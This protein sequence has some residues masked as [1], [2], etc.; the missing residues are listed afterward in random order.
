MCAQQAETLELT[1]RTLKLI[2]GELWKLRIMFSTQA[3]LWSPAV[4][5][6]GDALM[7]KGR[8]RWCTMKE[9]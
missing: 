4:K 2:D 5:G 3:R 7:A 6:G 8:S 9:S 1:Y